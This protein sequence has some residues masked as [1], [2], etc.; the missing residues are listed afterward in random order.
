MRNRIIFDNYHNQIAVSHRN[1]DIT[2]S[3]LDEI[4]EQKEFKQVVTIAV[5]TLSAMIGLGILLSSIME[6]GY[7]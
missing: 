6:S 4:K 5:I 1:K 2:A 7:L 3:E